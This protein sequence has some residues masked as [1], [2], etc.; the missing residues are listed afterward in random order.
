MRL[1]LPR[2][3][4]LYGLVIGGFSIIAIG[5]IIWWSQAASIGTVIE[6]SQIGVRYESP[7]KTLDADHFKFMYKSVY[8]VKR[9]PSAGDDIEQYSL[10]ADTNYLKTLAVDLIKFD[11]DLNGDVTYASRKTH[12]DLYSSQIV[13]V[14]GTTAEEFVKTDL[15]ERTVFIPHGKSMA[16]LS[17]VS[18]NKYEDLQT[19]LLALLSTFQWKQ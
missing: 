6:S 11:G 8:G 16:I 3:Q 4:A 19:E 12:P 18:G 1:H 9:L 17:F 7:I 15:S 13:T 14:D 5:G 10:T 2:N